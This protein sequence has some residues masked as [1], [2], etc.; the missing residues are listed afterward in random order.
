L[1]TALLQTL[2]GIGLF[3]FGMSVMTSGL[4]K[5][6]GARLRDWIARSTRNPVTGALTGAT[7]TALVQSSSAT[8]VAAIG[9]VGAGLMTFGSSLG[10]IFGANI[11][12]TITGWMVALLGFKVQLEEAALALLFIAAFCYL[13]KQKKRIRGFGKA[14]AGFCLIF[15]GIGYLKAGLQDY[16]SVIDLSQWNANSMGGRFVLLLIGILLTLVTQ[17][18]SATVATALTALNASILDLP[19]TAAVIIGADIGTTATAALATLGGSTASRRT[20]FA[21]VIYNVLTGIGA[22]FFLPL[23]LILVARLWPGATDGS[24]EMVAVGFHST[25]NILGVVIALPFTRPFGWLIKRLFPERGSP[26]S[27]V[28]DSSLLKDPPVA[29]EGLKSGSLRTAKYGLQGVASVLSLEKGLEQERALVAVLAAV[30]AG[31]QYAVDI[32]T[33]DDEESGLESEGIFE[34]LHLLDHV[35]RLVERASDTEL[36]AMVATSKELCRQAGEIQAEL[37]ALVEKLS[38]GEPPSEAGEAL[39]ARAK[40]MEEERHDFRQKLMEEAR[41]GK[42]SGEGL[43]D[44]LDGRRWLRRIT[45]HAARIVFYSE[46]LETAENRAGSNSKP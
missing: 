20:G 39:K 24:P 15:L 42:M 38:I 5:L 7:A 19:Q 6:A 43:D 1:L 30:D 36:A 11:G 25:F 17:S 29:L 3:L 22:F 27:V 41:E 2:G 33:A 26:L 4:K 31:R 14:L 28:F 13:M 9:F 45:Y 40:A 35:E 34:S 44:L 10:I 23:Y 32:G 8:T 21:H 12:T 16:Q 46:K 18:S 37:L